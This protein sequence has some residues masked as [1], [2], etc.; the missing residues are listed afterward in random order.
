MGTVVLDSS[1]VIGFIE[2]RDPCHAV[3]RQAILDARQN[4][5]DF[6][7]PISV[8]SEVLVGAYRMGTAE[9]RH[10]GIVRVFGDAHPLE[11]EA[12]LKAA[13]LRARHRSLRLPDALVVA[14]GVVEQATVLTC[15]KRLAGVDDC[16]QVIPSD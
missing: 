4:G 2:A 6:L 1:V 9:E 15:D 12:A 13:E 3:S 16:V 8:L 5:A 10:R 14:T 7:L 11:E